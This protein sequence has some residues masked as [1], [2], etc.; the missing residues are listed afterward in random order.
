MRLFKHLGGDTSR[1]QAF[2][3]R[4]KGQLPEDAVEELGEQ[5]NVL[6][7]MDQLS[8]TSDQQRNEAFFEFMK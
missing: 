1:W 2:V 3:S 6:N 8:L 4:L 7:A 5:L